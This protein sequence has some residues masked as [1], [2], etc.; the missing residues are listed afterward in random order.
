MNIVL[1]KFLNFYLFQQLILCFKLLNH[2]L[3][4][5]S[6]FI[7]WLKLILQCFNFS[8]VMCYNFLW[9]ARTQVFRLWFAKI[10]KIGGS[11]GFKTHGWFFWSVNWGPVDVTGCFGL[12]EMVKIWIIQNGILEISTSGSFKLI[13]FIKPGFAGIKVPDLT[14]DSQLKRTW[15]VDWN[16][17]ISLA[18]RTLSKLM[19]LESLII[20]SQNINGGDANDLLLSILPDQME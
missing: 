8:F 18:I 5:I 7:S 9:S 19:V 13:S 15:T 1:L 3:H 4:S 20:L 16:L 10:F 11:S 6:P 14:F 17:N 12:L 2:L